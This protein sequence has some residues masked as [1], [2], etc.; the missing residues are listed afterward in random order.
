M[1]ILF[2]IFHIHSNTYLIMHVRLIH[3]CK[4][5]IWQRSPNL[6]T[7]ALKMHSLTVSQ[8]FESATDNPAE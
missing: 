2:D 4:S 7:H 8:V 3:I 5:K 6:V 1:E